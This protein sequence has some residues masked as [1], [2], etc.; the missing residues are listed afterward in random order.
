MSTSDTIRVLFSISLFYILIFVTQPASAKTYD[1]ASKAL[2]KAGWTESLADEIIGKV[3]ASKGRVVAVFDHDNTLVSGDI[4]EGNEKSQPGFIHPLLLKMWKERSI[5]VWI[6]GLYNGDPW[7]F[8][9]NWA[10]SDPQKAYSWICT[11]LSGQRIKKVYSDVSKY[12]E[13]YQKKSIFPEM[14][15]LVEVLQQLGV[16][17]HIVSASAQNLV[18]VASKYYNIP[19]NRIHGI[20]L[21]VKDGIIQPKVIQPISFAAGKTW[22]INHFVSKFPKGNILVFGDSYRTDGHMLRFAARQGGFAL[23][24][25]PSAK[26][27]PTLNEN[28]IHYYSLPSLRLVDQ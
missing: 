28:G 4:T 7:E 9:C 14:K 8:Y 17:V 13:K 11:L 1:D 5:P 2:V 23:L 20:R 26:I 15:T 27:K 24:V 22:Y 3:K 25:N 6:E 16:E 12:Y 18:I 10:D 21:K 19:E